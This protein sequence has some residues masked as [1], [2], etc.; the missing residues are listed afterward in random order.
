MRAAATKGGTIPYIIS[1]YL[2]NYGL[3]IRQLKVWEK[4]NKIKELPKLLK[5]LDISNCVITI[6]A[7]GWQKSIAK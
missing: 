1:S 2:G 4:T 5:Q 7:I 6:D 3:S